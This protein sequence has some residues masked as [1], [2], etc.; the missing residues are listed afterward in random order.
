M[1]YKVVAFRTRVNSLIEL[2]DNVV[3]AGVILPATS[4][5][6]FIVCLEPIEDRKL[7]EAESDEEAEEQSPAS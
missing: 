3:P 4:D 1:Q 2:K 7:P 5:E 6:M